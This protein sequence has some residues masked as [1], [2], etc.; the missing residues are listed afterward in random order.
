MAKCVCEEP[1]YFYSGIP[2]IIAHVENGEFVPGGVERCDVCQ[3][4]ASD[5]SALEILGACFQRS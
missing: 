4:V 5:D 2:G 3:R 1:G